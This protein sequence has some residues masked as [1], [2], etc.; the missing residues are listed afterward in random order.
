MS[1]ISIS[2]ITKHSLSV[3]FNGIKNIDTQIR[4][5]Y[6]VV[7]TG[8]EFSPYWPRNIKNIY[9]RKCYAH[10]YRYVQGCFCKPVTMNPV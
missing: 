7:T 1:L 2:E 4:T 8:Y 10:N 6:D 9:Y 3:I 5:L